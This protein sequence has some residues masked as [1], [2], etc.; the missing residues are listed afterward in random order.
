MRVVRREVVLK[1]CKCA[2]LPGYDRLEGEADVARQAGAALD[3]MLVR[4]CGGAY[5]G[6]VAPAEQAGVSKADAGEEQDEGDAVGDVGRDPA[7]KKGDAADANK[8]KVKVGRALGV[9][10]LVEKVDSK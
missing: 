4:A 2:D 5:E 3:R 1:V 9:G 8:R 6:L 7:A 10:E